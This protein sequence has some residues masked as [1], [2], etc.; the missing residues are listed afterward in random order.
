MHQ[1]FSSHITHQL[2]VYF[3]YVTILTFPEFW[4][5]LTM[6][7]YIILW[8]K[9][10]WCTIFSVYFVDFIYKLYMFRNSLVPSS[11]GITVCDTSYFV[12]LYSE[13]YGVQNTFCTPDSSLYKIMCTKLVSFTRFSRVFVRSKDYSDSEIGKRV[14]NYFDS[15]DTSP[16]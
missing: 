7:L 16:S 11:G 5:L 2:L 3:S 6:H 15:L 12:I 9:P 14:G 4:A 10:M 1:S 8:M 13:L